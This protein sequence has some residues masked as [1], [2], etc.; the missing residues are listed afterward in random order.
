VQFL[1]SR[2]TLLPSDE[3][4]DDDDDD[5]DDD[6]NSNDAKNATK[7]RKTQETT[8]TTKMEHESPKKEKF[9]LKMKGLPTTAKE[10]SSLNAFSNN[11][12]W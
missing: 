8:N 11:V 3:E 1:K 12:D 6:Y 7:E 5:S 4:D 2:A 9:V 10:V